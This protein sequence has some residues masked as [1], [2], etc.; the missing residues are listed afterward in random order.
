MLSAKHSLIL[1]SSAVTAVL[2]VVGTS[3]LLYE[4][5]GQWEKRIAEATEETDEALV[6]ASSPTEVRVRIV[7]IIYI[8]I[9]KYI[10]Y[11]NIYI[12][13][14]YSLQAHEQYKHLRIRPS[15]ESVSQYILDIITMA[16]R[17]QLPH[18][19]STP[20]AFPSLV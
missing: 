7:C 14:A 1:E 3:L 10:L 12:I 2:S 13:Y 5:M 16:G 8:K 11:I 19:P 6:Y 15:S 9:Q 4:W 20:D 18:A 17:S